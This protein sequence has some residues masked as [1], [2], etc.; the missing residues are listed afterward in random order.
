MNRTLFTAEC[1]AP[2]SAK[3]AGNALDAETGRQR[4]SLESTH[5]T[6]RLQFV[7]LREAVDANKQLA[8][9]HH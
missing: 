9:H 7:A 5:S 1:A 3:G 6:D 8:R 4:R 2:R